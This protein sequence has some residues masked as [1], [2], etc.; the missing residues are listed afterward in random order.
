MRNDAQREAGCACALELGV[1][2]RSRGSGYV[3]VRHRGVQCSTTVIGRRRSRLVLRRMM[4]DPGHTQT[5]LI[6]RSNFRFAEELRQNHGAVSQG[7]GDPPYIPIRT[8]H[9]SPFGFGISL[10]NIRNWR[11]ARDPGLTV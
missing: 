2:L 1:S 9:A 6:L 11:R 3:L 8:R 5:H 4:H 10:S 7:S